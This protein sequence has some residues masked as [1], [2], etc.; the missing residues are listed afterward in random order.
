MT[1]K[2]KDSPELFEV[3]RSA[4]RDR[5]DGPADLDAVSSAERESLVAEAPE[6]PP[7]DEAPRST[8]P[9]PPSGMGER[10]VAVKYNTVVLG[11]MAVVGFV[12]IAFAMGVRWG[13]DRSVRPPKVAQTD[14]A[15]KLAQQLGPIEK[16]PRDPQPPADVVSQVPPDDGGTPTVRPQDP[17]PQG[18]PPP[19]IQAV[20]KYWVRLIDFDPG[21]SSAAALVATHIRKLKEKGFD[22]AMERLRRGS[23]GGKLRSVCYG[24]FQTRAQASEALPRLQATNPK[25][26]KT[27]DIICDE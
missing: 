10:R 18:A 24:P 16:G 20:G 1:P 27:A 2:K 11:L 15:N 6:A 19:P 13:E 21:D 12:F 7:R 3:F 4:V 5:E 25:A 23:G 22:Q 14:D 26:F 9:T 8:Q 17:T